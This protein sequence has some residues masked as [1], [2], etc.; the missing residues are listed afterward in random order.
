M[1]LFKKA[2]TLCGILLSRPVRLLSY[3]VPRDKRL[4]VFVGWHRFGDTEYFADNSK[5]LFLYYSQHPELGITPVW[6]S[7]DDALVKTLRKRGYRSELESSLSG[8]WC[9]LR[10]SVS[11]IDANPTLHLW[12][13]SGGSRLIQLWH[14]VSIKKI[15]YESSASYRRSTPSKFFQPHL[16]ISYDA[17]FAPSKWY[18]DTMIRSLHAAPDRVYVAPY[19]RNEAIVGNIQDAD[20]GTVE[21][22]PRTGK[23]ILYAPTFRSD[24]SNA[25]ERLPQGLTALLQK[26]DATLYI[27]THPKFMAKNTGNERADIVYL[28]PGKDIYP[29]MKEFDLCI[30]DYSSIAYDYLHLDR[31]VIFF[32][33]D[34]DSYETN[35]G[36]V[37]EYKDLLPGPVVMTGEELLAALNKTLAGV[38]MYAT[39]RARVRAIAFSAEG[40]GTRQVAE[41]I[42]TSILR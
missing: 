35:P 12:R 2:I 34:R 29:A 24:G 5:Y 10:A 17:V 11:I 28:Q 27:L 7:S 3:L 8:I 16:T 21:V 20:I 30:T 14:G 42:S 13:Y 40:S 22:S 36:L 9:A 33:F 4:F 39:E 31:P 41:I 1:R 32:Q 15:G 37:R 19:P 6:L 38:D 23:K 25:A 26:H 18:R